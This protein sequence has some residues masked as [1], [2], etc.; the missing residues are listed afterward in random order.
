MKKVININFQG[1]V[2]PIEENAYELLNRYVESLRKFFANEEGRDEIIN[3]IEGRVAELFGETLK[4]GG[5]CI[6]EDDVNRIID[7]MG[8]PE[9]FDGE[10]ANVQSQLGGEQKQQKNSYQQEQQHT[11]TTQEAKKLYRDENNKVLGG[12]CSGMAN[13]FGIDPLVARILFVIFIGVTFVPY[14]ILWVAVP[15][16]ATQVI[17]SVRKRLFRDP[18]DKVIAGVC[19]GLSQYFGVS[20]WIPRLLFLIPFFSFIFRFGHWGWWDFPHFLSVS[21]SP[22]S[23]FIYVILWMVLPE[24]KTSADKLEMKGEKVDL[25]N[26]KNTIQNDLEGFGKRAQ[27]FG[28]ELG[29]RAST[30]GQSLGEK[31]KEFG[32]TVANKSNQ[33]ANEASTV[34]RKKSRGLGDVII[35]IV[36]IFAYFILGSIIFAVVAALFGLG[37]AATGLMPA[38]NYLLNQ[39][40]QNVFAWGTLL[41]FIWVPV[42][43]IV[44]FIIRRITKMKGNSNLIRYSFSGLWTLGWVCLI[45]LIASLSKE[46]KYKNNPQE[47]NIVLQNARV[48]K[49]EVKANSFGKYYRNNWFE[50]EPFASL[51]EDTVFVRNVRIR[52][53][54]TSADS[55]SVKM[56]KFSNGSSKQRANNMVNRMNYNITQSDSTL[57]LEKGISITPTEKF[58]NQNVIVTIAVPIGKRIIIRSNSG[59]HW[60]RFS[61]VSFGPGN[62][63]DN[64]WYNDESGEQ[65]WRHDVEYIM[66]EQGLKRTDKKEDTDN[67]YNDDNENYN[68]KLKTYQKSKEELQKEFEETQRKAEE[69]KKE[70]QNPAIDS[71]K[72]KYKPTK[73]ANTSAPAK[74]TVQEKPSNM[75]NLLMLRYSI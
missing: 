45:C 67:D 35:L 14:L 52:I 27:K 34:A 26:I 4:K 56:V 28:E 43:G 46:F 18:D 47:E 13:Y 39:G 23:L 11:Y 7:S 72:Y 10:E 62:D 9:D 63:W 73:P 1:R 48:G 29:E 49:L 32:E 20:I 69:L 40:W 44:V 64:D 68:E 59:W 41:L 57:L 71:S 19:S 50:I 30:I 17:G 51:D 58:R 75:S 31:G 3:D 42:V 53:L 21:F 74:T 16:T 60:D 25:N 8:R 54:K 12:V 2:I 6:T 55:F 22:G 36:K 33:F 38:K 70:L 37:V 5:T 61:K 65:N 24:A 15:S 66:T